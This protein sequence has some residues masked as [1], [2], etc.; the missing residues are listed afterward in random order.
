MNMA[1]PECGCIEFK[2]FEDEETM[3]YQCTNCMIVS[4]LKDL[5]EKK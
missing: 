4:N 3:Y 2:I 5:V 1:C